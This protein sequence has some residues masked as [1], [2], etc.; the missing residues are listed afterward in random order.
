M[1]EVKASRRATWF[2][3][4]SLLDRLL[5]LAAPRP[6]TAFAPQPQELAPG[7]WVLDRQLR[8]PGGARL[9]SRTTII[10]LSGGALVVISPP[11]L[12]ESGGA[13]AIDSIG[14]VR[15][16]V[17]P[18]TFHYVYAAEFM[19]RYPDAS[20]LVAPGLLERVPELPP[21]EEL[22]PS[23]PEVWSG[24][25]DFVVLGPVRG[26]SEVVFFH[27]PTGVLILTDLAFNLTH[28]ARSFD[29]IAWRLTGVLDG[30]GPSRT[31]RSLLLRDHA[32]ASRCLSRVSEWPI[33]QIVVAHG[34]LVEHNAKAQFLKAFARYVVTP[35]A[36]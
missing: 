8:L 6:V 22:G 36:T 14:V 30:F 2:S 4:R 3:R 7:V 13:A 34:E 21:A 35:R 11:H 10:R 9:P 18:N 26:V 5:K 32:E 27:L 29:R 17:A 24:E 28:F 1:I 19:A 25:L 23:P 20:L 15:Q 33:R 12:V 16:V 31:A